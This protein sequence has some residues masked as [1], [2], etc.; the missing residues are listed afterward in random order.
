MRAARV[1][2]GE[3]RI[4]FTRD[5]DDAGDVKALRSFDMFEGSWTKPTSSPVPTSRLVAATPLRTNAVFESAI[6]CAM[7]AS[8]AACP[9]DAVIA[10][11]V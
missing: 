6:P 10:A 8:M 5:R 11:V 3:I 9:P 1:E 2:G 4:G 7:R